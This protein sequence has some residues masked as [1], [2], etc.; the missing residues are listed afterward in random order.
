L[1]ERFQSGFAADDVFFDLLDEGQMLAKGLETRVWSLSD[2]V[3]G[4]SAESNELGVYLVVFGPLQ[5]EHGIGPHL[6]GLKE[7]YL[8]RLLT[9]MGHDVA[10]VTTASFDSDAID[11]V[12]PQPGRKFTPTT[13]IIVDTELIRAPRQGHIQGSFAGVDACCLDVIVNHL[14]RPHPC[15]A[16]PWFGQPSGSDEEPDAILLSSSH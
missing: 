15:D 13:Q 7:N 8:D 10:F 16:N 12:P 1:A 14:R 11:F 3:S 4:S 2:F 9:Q 6:N 5:S